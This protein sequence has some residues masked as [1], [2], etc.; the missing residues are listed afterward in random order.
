VRNIENR[1]TTNVLLEKT[2]TKENKEHVYEQ[3]NIDDSR[4]IRGRT[5]GKKICRKDLKQ[6][7]SGV[8]SICNL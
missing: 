2:E 7:E 4:Q 8:T 1:R 6:I 3:R 5:N